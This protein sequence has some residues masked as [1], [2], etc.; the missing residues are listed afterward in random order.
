MANASEP[1][2]GIA[3]LS[4]L[5]I[6]VVRFADDEILWVNDIF[7][8]NAG[9]AFEEV[10]G[11]TAADFLADGTPLRTHIR[12]SNASG[13]ELDGRLPN[14]EPMRLLLSARVAD[15]AG[16]TVIVASAADITTHENTI[17]ELRRSR[18]RL[19]AIAELAPFPVGVTRL[20]DTNL[21]YVNEA[22]CR[23]MHTTADQVL[24]RPAPDFYANPAD[25]DAMLA[26]LRDLGTLLDYKILARLPDGTERTT[27]TSLRI[28]DFDGEPSIMAAVADITDWQA[29]ESALQEERLRL[30]R[31]LDIAGD[32]ILSVDPDMNI[33][34]FNRGAEEAFGYTADEVLGQPLDV[35]IPQPVRAKHR[36]LV[37]SF[38][39]SD[40]HARRMGLRSPV[41]GRRKDGTEFPAG[42]SIAKLDLRGQQMFTAIVRDLSAARDAEAELER[43]RAQLLHSQKMEAVGRLAGGVAHDFNNL[44]TAVYGGCAMLT[45]LLPTDSTALA[46]VDDIQ[47]A[48]KHAAQLTRQLL[49]ISRKQT[50]RR[51]V[52]DLNAALTNMRRMLRRLVGEHID[53]DVRPD[54][55][56]LRVEVDPGQLEQVVLNLVINAGDAIAQRGSIAVT[57]AHVELAHA[58]T[59]STGL[60][61]AGAWA[62]L[63]IADNGR[64]M[65]AETA[66]RAFEPFYTT[67]AAGTGLGLSTVAGIV[68]QSGGAIDVA[69]APGNGTTFRV[70]LPACVGDEPAVSPTHATAT[71]TGGTERILVAEDDPRVRRLTARELEDLG[72]EVLV[73]STADDALSLCRED[74]RPI[75]LLL[76]DVVLPGTSGREL[77]NRVTALRPNIKV[78]YMSG[79]P[80]AF[81]ATKGF[82]APNIQLLHKPF[83]PDDLATHVRVALDGA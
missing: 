2:G 27:L 47:S 60:V 5:P 35:L 57:T 42:V 53:L 37:A 75:A 44:L 76:T 40:E 64:G 72:Y 9:L 29:A 3:A 19:R 41:T 55:T 50:M 17:V 8:E 52:V 24:G 32:G 63:S 34:M 15:Y 31:M 79:Y 62:C 78:L 65:D 49:A 74:K 25:R 12:G 71:A 54:T 30:A 6:V 73:A 23:F 26:R 83:T 11:R 21:V 4:P 33:V 7:L 51:A 16:E 81:L 1:F 38:A 45:R 70:W 20:S 46:E 82:V 43:S 77:A 28:I 36:D 67:K 22:F 56:P 69:S 14:G 68:E 39:A 18:E 59:A 13:I 48:A 10:V 58:H 61:P 80:D 66:A